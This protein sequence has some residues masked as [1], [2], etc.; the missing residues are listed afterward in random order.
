LREADSIALWVGIG[1]AEQ[2]LIGKLNDLPPAYE[3]LTFQNAQLAVS[4]KR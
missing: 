4:R 2:L 1:T 3:R